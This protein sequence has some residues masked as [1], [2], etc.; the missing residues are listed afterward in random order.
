M[1][2]KLAIP[3]LIV[4]GMAL[5]ATGSSAAPGY[6]PLGSTFTYQG[7]LDRDGRPYTGSCDFQFSL[8][9][10]ESAGESIG[11]VIPVDDLQ[12]S[13]GLFIT[14]LDFGA[15]AFE[16]DARW[17]E[18]TVQCPGDTEPTTFPHQELT[19]VP[20][21]V[22]AS[23]VPW[24]GV[25]DM[26]EGFWDGVDNDTL[27]SAGEG[28]NL[29]SNTFSIDPAETQ[30]R[31]TGWCGVG[32]S[33]RF[34]N[35]DGSVDCQP[36]APLNRLNA[37]LSN[38]ISTTVSEGIAGITTSIT[39]NP[40]GLGLISYYDYSTMDLKL[41]TCGDPECSTA[42]GT[43][44]DSSGDVGKYSSIAIGS[45]WFPIISYF[46]DTADSLKAA[47]CNDLD[48]SNVTISTIDTI[49]GWGM[50]SMTIGADGL[51]LISYYDNS[52]GG[53]MVAHCDDADCGSSTITSLDPTNVMG[54][55]NSITIGADGLGLIS[56]YDTSGTDLKV[57]H[58]NNTNCTS[59]TKTIIDNESGY[60]GD[61]TSITTGV[62]GLGLI[63][64]YENNSLGIKVAHC[65]NAECTSSTRTTI[66]TFS[67]TE[68]S[69]TSITIGADGLG[70]VSY[71]DVHN[72][73][74]KIAHCND[75]A[76]STRYVLTVESV[77]TVGN[78][79]SI[80]IGTDGLPLISYYYEIS[81]YS[82]GDLKVLHC[83]STFCT[84]YF[85]RR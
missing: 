43:T 55:A 35:E 51:G 1:I 19:A 15:V 81:P 21:A 39:I 82:N 5:N 56:Y 48:C 69:V 17:L 62:D 75:V 53:L 65:S 68:Y 37:P 2:K 57:A 63:S 76:C 6:T 3:L 26:P 40:Y 77:G 29:S 49:G 4:I 60:I 58:C 41:A 50:T 78:F 66:D 30:K 16:G 32:S 31:I 27:Y 44:L 45:D 28:L 11:S 22:Y 23:S 85:R 59:A 42:T 83:G 70:V 84:P 7:R 46:D 33:F 71:Y 24:S 38:S 73:N 10:E 47:H 18:V 20:Y 61:S 13:D 9:D 14:K 72:G 8:W 67:G 25:M 74:L 36:D 12:V 80:T 34:I 52:G 64:Y 79:S 54:W